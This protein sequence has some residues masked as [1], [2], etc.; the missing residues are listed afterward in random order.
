MR[1]AVG[2]GDDFAAFQP[3][4]HGFQDGGVLGQHGALGAVLGQAE[5][6][7]RRVADD[8]LARVAYVGGAGEAGGRADDRT[9]GL[10]VPHFDQ[11]D[12]DFGRSRIE[13]RQQQALVQQVGA[14]EGAMQARAYEGVALGD[15]ELG[16]QFLARR[17]Q[18]V[19]RPD[20]LVPDPLLL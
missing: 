5:H 8:C 17:A 2:A 18:P 1:L 20:R 12:G 10:R 4:G 16:D 7:E 6:E 19:P 14:A 3:A 11:A 13:G 9:F 15:A